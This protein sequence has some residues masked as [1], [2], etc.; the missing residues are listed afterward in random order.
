MPRPTRAHELTGLKPPRL[1]ALLAM[2][3]VVEAVEGEESEEAHAALEH[4]LLASL[5]SALGSAHRGAR[6]RR[7]RGS[8]TVIDNQLAAIAELVERAADAAARQPERISHAA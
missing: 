2:R 4:A 5:A 1:D 7:A 3:G 8:Q 6:R